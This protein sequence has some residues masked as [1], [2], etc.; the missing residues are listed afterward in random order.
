MVAMARAGVRLADVEG[1][2]D[3][4]ARKVTR[5][6]GNAKVDLAQFGPGK[7]ETR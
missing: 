2:L 6:P 7:G 3:R 4:R 5:R 1:I